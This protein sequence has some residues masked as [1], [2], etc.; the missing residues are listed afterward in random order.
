MKASWSFE[1]L[2]RF[3]GPL[4]LCLKTWKLPDIEK[5]N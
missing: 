2:I 5:L 4:S 1:V 3:H